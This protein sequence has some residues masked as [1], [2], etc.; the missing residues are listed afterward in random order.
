M[1]ADQVIAK[2]QEVQAVSSEYVADLQ[3][4]WQIIPGGR[5]NI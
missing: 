1:S 5:T 2:F 4:A 3:K